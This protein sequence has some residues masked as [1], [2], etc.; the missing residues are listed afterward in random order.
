MFFRPSY[1]RRMSWWPFTRK[2]KPVANHSP[3]WYANQKALAEVRKKYGRVAPHSRVA[4][5]MRPEEGL[6][7]P[8]AIERKQLAKK[9]LEEVPKKVQSFT[10]TEKNAL[11]EWG[12]QLQVALHEEKNRSKGSGKN[13]ENRFI[14]LPIPI[15]IVKILLFVIG[16]AL[17]AMTVAT[18]FL[19]IA[20]VFM[21]NSDGS[22]PF[23]SVLLF[24][25]A[26]NLI[27]GASSYTNTSVESINS[28]V[29][30]TN[31]AQ[32][33]TPNNRYSYSTRRN[34]RR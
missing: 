15:I 11:I 34:N 30:T 10:S 28:S 3:E 23:M 12:Q 33:Y 8:F 6:H 22:N 16:F 17:L 18:I 1:I 29:A 13:I 25:Q 2:T 4:N 20:L 19:D 27:L 32:Q 14:T 26:S 5:V 9:F 7:D 31:P 21:N 24:N